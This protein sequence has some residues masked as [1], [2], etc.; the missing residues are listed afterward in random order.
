MSI[1]CIRPCCG[2]ENP[3]SRGD[4][5]PFFVEVIPATATDAVSENQFLAFAALVANPFGDR[6][7]CGFSRHRGDPHRERSRIPPTPCDQT[8]SCRRK[9]QRR[10]AILRPELELGF[11]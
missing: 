7:L 11:I 5:F 1:E 9:D 8:G 4:V 10:I 3:F 6:N 2:Y